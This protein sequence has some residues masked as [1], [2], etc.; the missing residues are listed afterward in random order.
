MIAPTAGGVAPGAL[1][2]RVHAGVVEQLAERHAR[3][4]AERGEVDLERAPELLAAPS[5]WAAFIHQGNPAPAAP[6]T[7][8]HRTTARTTTEDGPYDHR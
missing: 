1:A 7:G 8:P 5:S 4:V 2:S 3:A 6:P